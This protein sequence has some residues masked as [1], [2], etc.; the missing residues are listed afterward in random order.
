ML[1]DVK[2]CGVKTAVSKTGSPLYFIYWV[3]KI[4]ENGNGYESKS[5]I[6]DAEVYEEAEQKINKNASVRYNWTGRGNSVW[7][8]Q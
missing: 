1:K 3:E 2:I 8:I 6:C 5:G 7:T 4:D